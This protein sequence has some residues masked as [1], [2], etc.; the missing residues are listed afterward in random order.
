MMSATAVVATTG[1]A[2]KYRRLRFISDADNVRLTNV[3]III[4][5]LKNFAIFKNNHRD[6]LNKILHF[7]YSFN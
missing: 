2:K 3:C 4:I 5:I 1:S 7:S 6:L